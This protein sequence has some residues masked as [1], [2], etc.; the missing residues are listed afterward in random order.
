MSFQTYK[1]NNQFVLDI[2]YKLPGG[3]TQFRRYIEWCKET[4]DKDDW[5]FT[6]PDVI[7]FRIIFNSEEHRNFFLLKWALNE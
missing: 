4:F 7:T 2:M 6:R 1:V 3:F 5:E